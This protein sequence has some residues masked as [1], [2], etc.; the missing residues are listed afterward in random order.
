M[1]RPLWILAA[2]ILGTLIARLAERRKQYEASLQGNLLAPTKPPPAPWTWR[3]LAVGLIAAVVTGSYLYWDEIEPSQSQQAAQAPA[4]QA[5]PYRQIG[6]VK[7]VGFGRVSV[8]I[9]IP[10]GHS[11]EE[12]KATLEQVAAEL[13]KKEGVAGAAVFA[14]RPQD[15][16]SGGYTAGKAERAPNGKWSEIQSGGPMR[17]VIELAELYFEEVAEELPGRAIT[18]RSKSGDLVEISSAWDKWGD[19]QIIAEVPNGTK[20]TVLER[21][22]KVASPGY[23]I[24]RL[25]VELQIDGR[26]VEG[27]VFGD[28]AGAD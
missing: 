14:Y 26:R 15:Q 27:W 19:E 7:D 22:A 25:R 28:S 5:A 20:A 21:R 6:P 16:G 23:E 2:L 8:S 11:R 3:P 24:V 13:T 17:T 4:I 1:I 18:L 9:E 10:L 12:V